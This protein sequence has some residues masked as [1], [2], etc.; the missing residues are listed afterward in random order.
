M[1]GQLPSTVNAN[2]TTF[3]IMVMDVMLSWEKQEYDKA[4]G[5]KTAPEYSQADLQAMINRVRK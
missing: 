4:A 2:A 1:Y 3:D 5:V